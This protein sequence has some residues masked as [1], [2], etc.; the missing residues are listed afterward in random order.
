VSKG[1]ESPPLDAAT[2]AVMETGQAEFEA[3]FARIA[4]RFY[5]AVARERAKRY[6]GGLF[7]PA[8]LGSDCQRVR[9]RKGRGS[10][11]GRGCR[12]LGGRALALSTGSWCAEALAIWKS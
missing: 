10:T 7:A 8:P 4:P 2:A 3:L 6:L 1:K 11:T 5:R 9:E 12:W